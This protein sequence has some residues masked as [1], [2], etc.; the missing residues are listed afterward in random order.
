MGEIQWNPKIITESLGNQLPKEFMNL[1]VTSNW[2]EL[3]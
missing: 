1:A 2:F 3:M